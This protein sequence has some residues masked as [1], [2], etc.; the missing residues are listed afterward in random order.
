M[1]FNS[2][3]VVMERQ[4]AVNRTRK[5]SRSKLQQYE[6]ERSQSREAKRRS[7]DPRKRAKGGHKK[8]VVELSSDEE[9]DISK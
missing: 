5:E 7:D 3:V 4:E 9:S 1:K 6:E 8:I 2:N